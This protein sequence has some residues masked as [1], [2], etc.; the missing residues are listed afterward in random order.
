MSARACAHPIRISSVMFASV[1]HLG[2]NRRGFVGSWRRRASVAKQGQ[3]NA[4]DD[5]DDGRGPYGS[6]ANYAIPVSGACPRE[7]LPGI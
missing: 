2:P 6:A 7:S 5:P 4:G 3:G 1:L